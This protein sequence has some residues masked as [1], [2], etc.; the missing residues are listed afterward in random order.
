MLVWRQE[1]RK[2][3]SI[4]SLCA[5]CTSQCFRSDF[6]VGAKNSC[7][8]VGRAAS[9]RVMMISRFQVG[10]LLALVQMWLPASK[11]AAQDATEH[12]SA[13]WESKI[14][15]FEEQDRK[16]PPEPGQVL[17]IGSSSIVGWNLPKAFPD[18]KALNRG[19]GGVGSH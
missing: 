12:P 14:K 7:P 5:V 15:K 17:F 9:L 8:H 2:I 18:L 10:L 16:S 4:P 6:A 11:L 13:K 3:G 1:R 19:F